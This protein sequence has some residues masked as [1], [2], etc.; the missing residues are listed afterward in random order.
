MSFGQNL[1]TLRIKA[2]LSQAGLVEKT[3]IPVRTIQNWEIGRRTP[4]W[5]EMLAKL[6][7]GLNV[8]MEALAVS[9]ED[10]KEQKSAPSKPRGGRPRKGK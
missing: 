8:P 1:Q 3:G 7:R 5:I 10:N 6:A 4:G 9:K 2:G